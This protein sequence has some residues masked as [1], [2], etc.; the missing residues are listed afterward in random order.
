MEN[1][2]KQELERF[3]NN[4]SARREELGLLE[5]W[6]EEHDKRLYQKIIEKL[7]TIEK[8]KWEDAEHCTCL[9]Y[10]IDMLK[11]EKNS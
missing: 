5:Y 10:A 11:N 2:L 4:F 8:E 1:F 6:L 3:L 9:S 7:E